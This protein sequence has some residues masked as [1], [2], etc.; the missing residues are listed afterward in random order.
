MT[1]AQGL[2]S[3]AWTAAVIVL[4]AACGTGL[5]ASGVQDRSARTGGWGALF[6]GLALLGIPMVR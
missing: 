4:L 1:A 2:W 5:I 6:L 3:F